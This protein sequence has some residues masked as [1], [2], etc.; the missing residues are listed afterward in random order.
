M[1]K[2]DVKKYFDWL[3]SQCN[4]DGKITK[5][6]LKKSMAVDINGDGKIDGEREL[7]LV[8]RGLNEWIKNA[9]NKLDDGEITFDELC[10]MLC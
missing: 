7:S 9:G 2:V 5:E 6:E 3:D 10:E 1:N 8:Q 4:K